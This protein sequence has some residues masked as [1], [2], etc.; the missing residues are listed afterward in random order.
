MLGTDPKC[1]ICWEPVEIGQEVAILRPCNHW[2]QEDCCQKWLNSNDSCPMCR[3]KV[4]REL[5]I[6]EAEANHGMNRRT[7]LEV[8]RMRNLEPIERARE[9]FFYCRM[10]REC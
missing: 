4:K 7:V 1:P 9:A 3:I 10:Q 6:S 2:F 5:D 8:I